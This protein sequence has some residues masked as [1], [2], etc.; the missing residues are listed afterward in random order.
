MKKPSLLLFLF[1]YLALPCVAQ[2]SEVD[3]G[4]EKKEVK[5]KKIVKDRF[6]ELKGG[7][8]PLGVKDI[9]ISLTPFAISATETTYGQMEAFALA[10]G[11]DPKKFHEP[12]WGEPDRDMPALNVNWFD[13]IRYADWLS[14][15]SGLPSVYTIYGDNDNVLQPADTAY[16]NDK[17][18]LKIELDILKKGYRLPTEAEWEYAASGYEVLGRKQSWAGIDQV[19]SLKYYAWFEGNSEGK[20]HKTASLQPNVLGLYDMS[21][22]VWESCFDELNFGQENMIDTFQNKL[23]PFLQTLGKPYNSYRSQRGGNWYLSDNYCLVS[24]RGRDLAYHGYF[25]KGVRLVRTL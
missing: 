9:P 14:N 16:W 24:S 6:I 22:N 20:I 17:S 2:E 3:D 7:N 4:K 15:Q 5:E 18:W 25:N 1:L 12:K 8:Y 11:L 19:D 10:N 21:G 23:N 13:A